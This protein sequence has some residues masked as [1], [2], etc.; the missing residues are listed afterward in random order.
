MKELSFI[1]LLILNYCF[2]F[3][4][5]NQSIG[6]IDSQEYSKEITEY[7]IKEFIVKNVLQL[8]EREVVEIEI[9]AITAASSGEITVVIYRCESQNK[10]GMVFSFWNLYVNEY[11]T[12]SVEYNFK[13]FPFD[14]ANELLI[15]LERVIDEKKPIVNSGSTKNAVYKFDD[16][17]FIFYKGDIGENLIRVL[18]DKYDSQWNQLNLKST[19]KR[20]NTFFGLK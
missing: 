13:H 1:I 18:W 6:G 12:K 17:I 3:S 9:D 2:S 5:I 4:Q 11:N 10:K 16:L 14:T 20:F 19:H 15:E 7:K 8:P